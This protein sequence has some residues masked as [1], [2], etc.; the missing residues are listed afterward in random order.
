MSLDDDVTEDVKR[1]I[2]AGWQ[3]VTEEAEKTEETVEGVWWRRR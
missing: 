3:V 1:R 2:M